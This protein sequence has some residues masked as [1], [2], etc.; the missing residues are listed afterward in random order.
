MNTEHPRT[1]TPSRRRH[2]S[3]T[4]YR[5]HNAKETGPPV[6]CVACPLTPPPPSS[7]LRTTTRKS[8]LYFQLAEAELGATPMHLSQPSSSAAAPT[9]MTPSLGGNRSNHFVGFRLNI[10]QSGTT[11]C[12]RGVLFRHTYTCGG[13]RAGSQ[14]QG[15][16][17]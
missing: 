17:G 13:S 1:L 7:S 8:T 9:G 3:H 15:G 5:Q 6:A 12:C 10:G 14:G 4:P 2:V 16:E 11:S